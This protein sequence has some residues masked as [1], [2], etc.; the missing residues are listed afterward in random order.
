MDLIGSFVIA[1][2]M[3]SRIPMPRMEWTE[4]RMRYALCFFPFV[5]V[6]IAVVMT[7]CLRVLKGVESNPLL[8][9]C[10]GVVVP[11]VITGGIH[12]D[13]YL[14]VMDARSSLQ[15]RERKLEI[16]KDPHIGAF[17]VIHAGLYLVMYLGIF[18]VFYRY[19]FVPAAGVY[20][21]TRAFSGWSVV[22]FPKAKPDGTVRAFSDQAHIRNVRW[23]MIGWALAALLWMIRTGGW[24]F[25]LVMLAVAGIVMV[26]YRRVSLREFGG[27]TGDLA[28]YFLQLSELV[29]LAAA[30]GFYMIVNCSII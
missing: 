19:S 13:G 12:L 4:K 22:S 6:V 17:A 10:I 9:S 5:G 25:G 8:Y 15:S 27:I 1:C 14:D 30:A 18:S 26:W 16:L 29:M 20:V 23:Y 28:G 21:L 7:V 24:G 2:S 11:L 3:Y